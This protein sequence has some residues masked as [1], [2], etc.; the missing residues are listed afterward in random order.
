MEIRVAI[1]RNASG[2]AIARN[3][4]GSAIASSTRANILDANGRRVEQLPPG[5][6]FQAVA[7][8]TNLN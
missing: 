8:N 1:A 4:S 5:Q 3:A 7:S 2:S 6:A